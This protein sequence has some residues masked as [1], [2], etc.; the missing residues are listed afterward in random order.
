MFPLDWAATF[1][2]ENFL[3]TLISKTWSG[4]FTSSRMNL[5]CIP[6]FSR[7]RGHFFKIG[8]M[9]NFGNFFGILGNVYLHLVLVDSKKSSKLYKHFFVCGFT[10]FMSTLRLL[11][12]LSK[13]LDLFLGHF[14]QPI[15]GAKKSVSG[16][17][18]IQIEHSIPFEQVL[19]IECGLVGRFSLK[20]GKKRSQNRNQTWKADIESPKTTNF[21]TVTLNLM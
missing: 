8:V 13:A 4:P 16:F 11:K 3:M 20:N 12:K 2:K 10:R 15:R 9:G 19:L 5:S 14:S 17:T 1:Q 6:R 21:R 18:L 7:S